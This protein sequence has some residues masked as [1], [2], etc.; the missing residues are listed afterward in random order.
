MIP[1]NDLLVFALAAFVLVLTPGPNMIYLISRSLSQG[2]KAGL[3]SLIGVVCG[4]SFHIIMAAFGLTAILFAVPYA[5]AVL[6]FTGAAYL[7][8]LAF[9]AIQPNGKNIFV[10]DSNIKKDSPVRLFNMGFLTNALNPKAAFF[11][12][13]FLPQFI[14][15]HHGSVFTQTLQLGLVQ[16]T[17]SFTINALIVLFAAKMAGFFADNPFWVRIQKWFMASVLTTLAVK[18]AFTKVK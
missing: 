9:K 7:L 15:P 8:Y 2:K 18:M 1:V 12:L 10:T 16:A 4:F 11:Y 17:I 3:I 13:S 6:K 14:R 5:Y